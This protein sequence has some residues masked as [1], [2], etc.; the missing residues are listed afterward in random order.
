AGGGA[1]G[2]ALLVGL[3]GRDRLGEAARELAR[4]EAVQQRGLLR[5]RGAPGL[6]ALVPLGLLLRGAVREAAGVGQHVLVDLEGLL[7]IEADGL[8]ETLHALGAELRS[9]ERRVGK[10]CRS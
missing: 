4:E 9:E 8:L 2:A 6:V 3:E 7:G 10:E 1:G 5:V